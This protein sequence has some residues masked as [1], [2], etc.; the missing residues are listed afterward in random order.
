M[1]K[2]FGSFLIVLTL[3]AGCGSGGGGGGGN[4]N[5]QAAPATNADLSDLILSA[6]P[7]DQAFQANQTSYSASVGFLIAAT[8]VT[9]T[10]DDA[11]ATVTVNG[12]AVFSGT[13]SGSISLNEGANK[14]T[15]IVTAEDG[16][17]TKTYT[18]GVTRQS[19]DSFAQRAYGKASNAD[20]ND[21]FG[22][23]GAL[24]GDMLV[25]GAVGEG[26]SAIGGE[27]DN[28]APGAGAV[29]VFTWDNGVGSQQA[30]LKASNADAKDQFG[31]SVALSGDTLVVGA[32][33]EGGDDNSKLD[34]GAVYV[35]TRNND[36]EWV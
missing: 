1:Y 27:D 25:V 3:L 31:F 4:N 14:I 8:T 11:N 32:V 7:L 34:A 16:V 33:G 28:T 9:P 6:A 21:Q 18:I 5:I 23:S 24:S 2:I 17:T 19:A 15:V 35:F 20:E 13:A 22:F 12:A 26:S 30:Y 29:Y 10:T 36:G